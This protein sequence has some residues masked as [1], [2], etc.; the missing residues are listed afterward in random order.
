MESAIWFDVQQLK[1]LIKEQYGFDK[2]VETI[3]SWFKRNAKKDIHFKQLS[4]GKKFK[5]TTIGKELYFSNL[6]L[7]KQR[8]ENFS[9]KKERKNV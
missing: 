8:K 9:Q 6:D 4:I 7:E 5:I 3:Y 1:A 2:T